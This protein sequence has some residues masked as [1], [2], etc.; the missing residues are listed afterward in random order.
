M[1][2]FSYT[3][4]FIQP[5]SFS[6]PV[7]KRKVGDEHRQFQE[8]WEKEYFFVEHKGIPTCLICTDK[9]AAHKEYNIRRHY[10]TRHAEE[11][12]KYP[13]DE[14]EDRVAKLKT[15]LLRQQDF[16]KKASKESDAAVKASYVVSEMIAKAGKPFKDSEFIK[17]CMLQAASIVC[18]EK[19]GQFSNISLSGNTVAER[20]SD[21]SGNIYDQLRDKAKHFNSYSLARDESTDVTDTAQLAIYVRGVDDNFEVMEELLTMIAMHGQT[22]GQEI[23]RQLC[24]S[25]VDAG[26]LWK[27]FA[28]ITTDAINDRKEKWTG[29]TC[30]KK[31]GR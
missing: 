27:R 2:F 3:F 5:Q 22:T 25:I 9:V 24:D 29:G 10:S 7:V 17:Q 28:G 30:S 11:Y 21:M 8:K 26:L 4:F 14:R 16:F 13:G 18:P 15:G 19:K 31:T 12:A 6:K 20:I 1:P 23:F